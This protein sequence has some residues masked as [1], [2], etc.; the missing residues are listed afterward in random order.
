MRDY[1]EDVVRRNGDDGEVGGHVCCRIW[2][3]WGYVCVLVK[4][5]A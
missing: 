1:G 2:V 3:G 5:E 4:L